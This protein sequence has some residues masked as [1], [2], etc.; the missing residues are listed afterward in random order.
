VGAIQCVKMKRVE[1][2]ARLF[3]DGLMIRA[4]R[5]RRTSISIC[6]DLKLVPVV[7]MENSVKIRNKRKKVRQHSAICIYRHRTHPPSTA[8]FRT[9]LS[10]LQSLPCVRH[11][12]VLVLVD[13]NMKLDASGGPSCRVTTLAWML[14]FIV[15]KPHNWKEHNGLRIRPLGEGFITKFILEFDWNCTL[16]LHY[17]SLSYC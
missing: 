5:E 4:G 12:S 14:A 15:R 10:Q 3:P 13:L 6:S 11:S 2:L 16:K 17:N 9:G 1:H 7:E 8:G